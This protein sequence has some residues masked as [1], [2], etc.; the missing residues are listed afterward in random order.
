[1]EYTIPSP[2]VTAQPWTLTPDR[3][4]RVLGADGTII[5]EVYELTAQARGEGA[6]NAAFV[7]RACNA[8][9]NLVDALR[10]LFDAVARS[11]APLD[12][13]LRPIAE[14]LATVEGA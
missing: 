3:P 7:V 2:A 6:A 4:P 1:M 11:E 5:A 12:I 8:H 10:T 14:L 9:Q 13:E